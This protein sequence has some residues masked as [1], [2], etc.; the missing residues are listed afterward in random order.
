M[1]PTAPAP[2][3]YVIQFLLLG[4]PVLIF[5]L[6]AG[7]V[8]IR[9]RWKAAAIILGAVF[10]LTAVSLFKAAPHRQLPQDIRIVQAAGLG[11]GMVGL[12]MI[13]LSFRSPRPPGG[14]SAPV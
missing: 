2:D 5:M 7:T 12:L 14:S 1:T 13:L 9:R 4:V 6:V 3:P 8:A 10:L 11:C